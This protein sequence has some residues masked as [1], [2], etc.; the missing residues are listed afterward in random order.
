MK[1]LVKVYPH[2]NNSHNGYFSHPNDSLASD[3]RLRTRVDI[4]SSQRYGAAHCQ[5][6]K[7]G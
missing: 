7:G 2:K 5:R 3:R 6:R 1:Y 4:H